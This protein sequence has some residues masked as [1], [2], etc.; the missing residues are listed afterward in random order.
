MNALQ[1]F[2][3]GIAVMIG[4]IIALLLLL[5]I[6]SLIITG[7]QHL[8]ARIMGRPIIRPDHIRDTQKAMREGE[9]MGEEA[10]TFIHPS[11]NPCY[12]NRGPFEPYYS[13]PESGDPYDNDSR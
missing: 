12:P 8:K 4:I 7:Y 6:L 2:G 1:A 13:G 5:V 10:G 3:I 11:K 9:P